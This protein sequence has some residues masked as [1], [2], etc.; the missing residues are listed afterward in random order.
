M[1]LGGSGGSGGESGTV[2]VTNDGTIVTNGY[3]AAGIL[4]QSIVGAGG[5]AGVSTAILSIG[6]TGGSD[7]G[8]APGKVTVG[9]TNSVTTNADAAIGV[10]A[11]SVG[12]GGGSASGKPR[13]SDGNSYGVFTLGTNGGGGG[14]G[15]TVDITDVGKIKTRGGYAYGL[16][17]QSVGGGG[18]NGGDAFSGGVLNIPTAAIGGQSGGGGVGGDVTVA[19]TQAFD[20]ATAGRGAT[21]VFAQSV[22]G[23][24]GSGG[25]ATTVTAI[26]YV[27]MSI[28]GSG[29][30]GGNGGTANV[31]LDNGTIT[32]GGSQAAG[33][34]VQSI[35]GGGGSGGNASS[36]SFGLI[37]VGFALGGMAKGGGAGN[38]ASADLTQTSIET[39]TTVDGA[40]DAIGMLV[41]SIGGGGGT[42]GSSSASAI[43]TGIPIDPEDPDFTLTLNAQFALGGSGGDGG[44]GGTASAT[45]ADASSITTNGASSHGILVQSIGGG[46]GSG[47]DASTATTTFPDSTE[48]YGLTINASIGGAGG[49]GGS[50]GAASAT[51]GSSAGNSTPTT[52]TTNGQFANAVM[53]Q[54]IGGGGGNSG[55]PNSTTKQIAGNG[56]FNVTLNVGSLNVEASELGA[57]GGSADVTLYEDAVISTAGDGA[58]GVIAQSVGGG[59]GTVQGGNLTLSGEVQS[60]GGEEVAEDDSQATCHG[61]A[62]SESESYCGTVS[63]SLGGSGGQGGAGKDVTVTMDGATITTAGIDADGI[64]AQ[65]IGGGGG[66]AGSVGTTS[67]T[68]SDDDDS[69]AAI[70]NDDDDDDDDDGV[71][72]TLTASVGGSGGTGG[73]AGSVTVDYQGSITTTADWADGIVAQSIGGGGGIGGTAYSSSSGDTG[74]VDLSI[75]GSGG[76]GGS[77]GLVTAT[78]DDNAPGATVTTN[79]YMAHAVVLQSIGGGGGQGGDGSDSASGSLSL[80]G[81]DGGNG[82][83]SGDGDTVTVKGFINAYTYGDDAY[84]MVLQSIGGGGGIGG[85]GTSDTSAGGDDDYSIDVAVGGA[86]GGGGVGG[87]IDA[88][89][90]ANV[91]T[92]GAR[93]HGIIAQSIGGG[94]GI[95]GVGSA[96]NILSVNLGGSGGG[97]GSA[98][99]VTLDIT[100]GS[101]RTYYDGAHGIIAQSIGGGGGVA[102]DVGSGPLGRINRSSGASGDGAA[103][104]VTLDI[105]VST[106]GTYAHGIIAQSIGGGGGVGGDSSGTFAGA[107]TGG[108]GSS[109][110]AAVTVTANGGVST[111]GT[112]SV[113]IFAQSQ[114]PSTAGIVTV[115][116][117]ADITGGSGSDG[118][119]IFVADGHDN[120]VNIAEGSTIVAG[121]G[122]AAIGYISDETTAEGGVLTVNNAGTLS[123]NVTGSNADGNTAITVNN[124]SDQTL[125]DANLYEAHVN[126]AGRM[127]IGSGVYETERLTITGDFSQTR[128][129]T[130]ATVADFRRGRASR[131]HVAGDASLDGSIAVDATMIARNVATVITADGAITGTIEAVDTPA[132]DF[133]ARTRGDGVELR[134]AETRFSEAFALLSRNQRRVGGHLDALFAA[135]GTRYARILAD[136]NRLS[137]M[138]DGGSAYAQALSSLSPGG[139]QAAA[140]AQTV[141]S[142]GRLDQAMR[143]PAFEGDDA[144]VTEDA[145]TWAEMGGAVIDQGG[146]PGYDGTLWGFA[147]G[148]QAEFSENW[149][150]GFAAGYENSRYDSSDGFSKSDGDTV[151]AA[152]AVKREI[153][154]FQ[155]SGAVSGSYG[156]YDI[157]R[158]VVTPGFAGK[159]HGES[160]LYTL[161]A[162]GRIA[163]TAANDVAY[164]RPFLDVDALYAHSG[165]YTETGAGAYNL[166]VESQDQF[167]VVATPAVEIGARFK[168]SAGWDARFF[169]SAGLSLST[170]DEWKTEAKLDSAPASAG[171]FK[172]TLPVADV[173]ARIGAGVQISNTNG[174]DVRADYD[175]AFG[176]DYSNHSG[177]LR[178]VKRF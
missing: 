56:N 149:F 132:V 30:A 120:A 99:T 94:G 54:S 89:F 84:G 68:A 78:F 152:L 156:W 115:N 165:A 96:D 4:A 29:S 39:G 22:G 79:G 81:S 107:N 35:G 136:Y 82:G 19:N 161:G 18:G 146:A 103:V 2:E 53:V 46:G 6:G 69:V 26:D 23:G 21:G 98:N 137:A 1:A 169:A 172:T 72:V 59:G 177:S 90:G 111:T 65:S 95:G 121:S 129:G 73:Q 40:H 14:D 109:T 58:R 101:V 67:D 110:A 112:G 51:V 139:S 106:V 28:G 163:Y 164:V 134:V 43:T 144:M 74:Q 168:P 85:T 88:S 123:G 87:I 117:N 25:D 63:V 178:F 159:A 13:K 153:G 151:Y 60:S 158:S 130:T 166:D 33:V 45:L 15:G 119:A 42:G 3:G 52:I 160:D 105:P 24:G 12:G 162:R 37:S 64:L 122:G 135:D 145:C 141:L 11:Q 47:G 100:S 27:Q 97:G 32:T 77:G 31:T 93:A 17:A 66:L 57:D 104:S 48:Q 127:L 147:A 86:G 154:A 38:T 80:G 16:F 5:A 174:F 49:D 142:L 7:S 175:G 150:L 155:V 8:T 157:N 124:T 61:S 41:Q 114:A 131:L 126:N 173:L 70:T 36:R 113:G 92:F 118:Y 108:G 50:G 83:S 167:A 102:G 171:T 143:C 138:G 170:E 76:S 55:V 44:S 34:K 71:D 10:H 140:A 91:K 9:N 133:E 20:V 128:T 75:G 148:G 116:A 62:I 176:D 125:R